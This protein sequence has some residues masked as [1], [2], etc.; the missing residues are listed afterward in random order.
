MNYPVVIGSIGRDGSVVA[1]HAVMV[2]KDK[3]ESVIRAAFSRR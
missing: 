3:F 2:K 1:S